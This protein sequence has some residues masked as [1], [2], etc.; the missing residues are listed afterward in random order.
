MIKISGSNA[1][2]GPVVINYGESSDLGGPAHRLETCRHMGST[3]NQPRS[4]CSAKDAKHRI[5]S[6]LKARKE[7]YLAKQ[8]L[9][10]S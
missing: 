5:C 8:F 4:C 9:D 2:E 6:C 7:G 10:V 1:G 3:L